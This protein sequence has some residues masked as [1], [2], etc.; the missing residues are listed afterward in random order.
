MHLT[1]LLSGSDHAEFTRKSQL[2]EGE[3]KHTKIRIAHA[4]GSKLH[5]G[6]K[7]RP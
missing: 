2:T 7:W 6:N 5:T 3:N 4:D 1:T